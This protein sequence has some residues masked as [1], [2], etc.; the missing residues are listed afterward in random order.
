LRRA[1]SH[2]DVHDLAIIIVSTN[3]GHWLPRCLSSIFDRQGDCTLDVVVVDNECEDSTT[4]VVSGYPGARIVRSANRGFSHANNRGL[5]T[6]DA[7]YVLFL[8]P[9]TEVVEG[10]FGELVRLL[11]ARPTVGLA[12]VVQ[13][14]GEG[15]LYPTIRRFP[16]VTRALGESLLTERFPWPSRFT[17]ERE[18]DESE[19][20]RERTID[21]T[22]GAFMLCRREALEAAG[23][24]DERFF[25]YA[26]EVDLAYRIRLAG[27]EVRHLPALTIVHYAGKAGHVP[28][29]T[30]QQAY[31]LRQYAAKHF[32]PPRRLAFLGALSLGYLARAMA[33]DS[34][35]AARGR[36]SSSRAALRVLA[37]LDGPP[38][39]PPP[40][41]AVA[42]RR[43]NGSQPG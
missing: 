3:E 32:A 2:A 41:Q 6:C 19:Y 14:T 23:F 17:H 11:D 27:W 29:M 35:V 16:S 15:K 26:E 13:L 37:G 1:V 34:N 22:T 38:F 8:N 36:R 30:A 4:E 43:T 12:G 31:A 21:W 42:L 25:I 24:L 10:T 28:R 9:D 5:M 40:D 7:R 39:G 18:L 20:A 33:P